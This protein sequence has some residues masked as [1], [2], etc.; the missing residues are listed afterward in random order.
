VDDRGVDRLFTLPLA[1]FVAAR[2]EL[3]RSLKARGDKETAARI[4]KLPKP[5]ISAWATNQLVRTEPA[6]IR[7]LLSSLDRQRELQLAGLGAGVDRNAMKEAKQAENDA[8]LKIERALPAILDPSGHA[9]GR[10]AIERCVRAIRAAAVHTVGRPLLENGHLTVD[11]D[12]PGFEALG[13]IEEEEAAPKLRLVPPLEDKRREREERM[14]ELQRQRIEAQAKIEEDR[15]RVE[16]RLEEERVQKRL[17]EERELERT[18]QAAR[19]G[20]AAK[21]LGSLRVESAKLEEQAMQ[22]EDAVER[23]R[24]ALERAEREAARAK[25]ELAAKRSQIANLEEIFGLQEDG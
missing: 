17:S 2:N 19:L 23:A 1:D 16:E 5:S 7:E 10:A 24:I 25:E 9:S 8:I 18:K 14:K 13:A 3:A 20:E 22:L 12:S 4:Q 15:R 11:F 21:I 6:L